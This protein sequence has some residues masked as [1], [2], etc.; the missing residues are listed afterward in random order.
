M[1]NIP[2]WVILIG[3]IIGL[4]VVICIELLLIKRRKRVDACFTKISQTLN[5]LKRQ[6][7]IGMSDL[8]GMINNIE[9]SIDHR[10]KTAIAN[11][12]AEFVNQLYRRDRFR[13]IF[14]EDDISEINRLKSLGKELVHPP[15][16]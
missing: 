12:I 7:Y 14:N 11:L 1:A 5:I 9:K 10:D 16:I 2:E 15:K 4:I 13:L 3:I 8:V 6:E